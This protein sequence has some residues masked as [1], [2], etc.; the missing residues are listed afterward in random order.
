[1]I[2]DSTRNPICVTL[3]LR[4][5][6]GG[7]GGWAPHLHIHSGVYACYCHVFYCE[8][9]TQITIHTWLTYK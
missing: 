9:G 8:G 5:D 4:R 2:K 3:S 7:G 1:M 6:G